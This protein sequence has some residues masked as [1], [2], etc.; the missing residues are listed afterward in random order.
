MSQ[1]SLN[2]EEAEKTSKIRNKKRKMIFK[3]ILIFFSMG[4]F[5]IGCITHELNHFGMNQLNNLTNLTLNFT[6][7][8]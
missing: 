3:M 8:Y 2:I 5:A 6:D 7:S 1:F 4:V